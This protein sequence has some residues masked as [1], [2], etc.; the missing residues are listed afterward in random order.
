[1]HAA[2]SLSSASQEMMDVAGGG[3]LY[4]CVASQPS[5]AHTRYVMV[6]VVTVENFC[7]SM[8]SK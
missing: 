4:D 6:V 8:S 1:M 3:W 7:V 5:R 2:K